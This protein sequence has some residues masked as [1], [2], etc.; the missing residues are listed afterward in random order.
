M[1]QKIQ[2]AKSFKELFRISNIV[3]KE[4][5]LEGYLESQ[6]PQRDSFINAEE[7]CSRVEALI[8]ILHDIFKFNDG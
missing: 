6:G 5:F 1:S 8:I 4:S 3:Y 2:P 7:Q